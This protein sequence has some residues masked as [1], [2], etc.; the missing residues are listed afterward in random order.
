MGEKNISPGCDHRNGKRHLGV[1]GLYRFCS[2]RRTEI[3][4]VQGNEQF[5]Y[6]KSQRLSGEELFLYADLADSGARRH[7]RPCHLAGR[8]EHRVLLSPVLQPA[9]FP[10]TEA[11]KFYGPHHCTLEL[12]RSKKLT[13]PLTTKVN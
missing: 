12:A 4:R 1:T 8:P 6:R 9:C 3:R 13:F 5:G 11:N 10:A 2:T 7:Y